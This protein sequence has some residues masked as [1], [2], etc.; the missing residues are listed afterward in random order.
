MYRGFL[1]VETPVGAG[2]GAGAGSLSSSRASI[3]RAPSAAEI[4]PSWIIIKMR[5]LSSV[6]AIIFHLS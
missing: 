5:I 1:P 3:S 6:E 4:L 2:G